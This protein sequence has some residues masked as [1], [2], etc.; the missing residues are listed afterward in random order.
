MSAEQDA[1]ARA[2]LE[3]FADAL[4]QAHG[5]CFAGRAAL[6]DW[7]DDQ[8]LR[9]ARLDVPDQMAGPMINT[10]YLLWQAEIAGLSDNQE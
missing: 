6:M 2:L 5:P 8:F 9:L 1:A 3:M 4:E 10:A 7:I